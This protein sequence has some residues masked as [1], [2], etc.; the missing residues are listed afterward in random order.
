MTSA[1]FCRRQYPLISGD[2]PGACNIPRGYCVT[3]WRHLNE[4]TRACEHFSGLWKRERKEQYVIRSFLSLSLLEEDWDLN[5]SSAFS[6]RDRRPKVLR[7]PFSEYRAINAEYVGIMSRR[8]CYVYT[9]GLEKIRMIDGCRWNSSLS[10]VARS[11]EAVQKRDIINKTSARWFRLDSFLRS[12]CKRK[13]YRS[14]FLYTSI[15]VNQENF[16]KTFYR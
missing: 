14:A 2:I 15:S 5:T 12:R 10:C 9:R 11:R 8:V 7:M 6:R 3:F 1:L 13:K 16:Q 4:I